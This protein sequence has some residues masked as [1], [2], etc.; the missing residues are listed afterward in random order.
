[1]DHENNEK[2]LSMEELLSGIWR[3]RKLALIIVAAA[4]AIGAIYGLVTPRPFTAEAVVRV[5]AQHLPEQFVSP[6]VSELVT[7][8]LATVRHELLSRPVLASVIEELNL[9]GEL[10]QEDGMNAAV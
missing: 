9:F 7:E 1:M 8:R 3:R 6:T 10:R 5:D 4:V 2:S